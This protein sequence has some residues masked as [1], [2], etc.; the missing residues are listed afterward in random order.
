MAIPV[1]LY[2]LRNEG[3][4]KGDVYKALDNTVT[5]GHRM[6]ELEYA[7]LIRIGSEPGSNRQFLYLTNEGHRLAEALDKLNSL[8]MKE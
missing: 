2:I 8:S 1:L 7:G 6:N 4:R 3:C 5:P